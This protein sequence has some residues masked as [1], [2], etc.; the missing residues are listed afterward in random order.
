MIPLRV[1]VRGSGKEAGKV[2][3]AG[4]GTRRQKGSGPAEHPVQPLP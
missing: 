2:P 3:A 1:V 4:T